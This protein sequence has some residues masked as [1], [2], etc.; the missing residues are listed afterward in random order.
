VNSGNKA[1]LAEG[2]FAQSMTA[3]FVSLL[4][5]IVSFWSGVFVGALQ[6]FGGGLAKPLIELAAFLVGVAVICFVPAGVLLQHWYATKHHRPVAA[7]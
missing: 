5:A 7:A 1:P 3:S 4:S 2:I 6:I